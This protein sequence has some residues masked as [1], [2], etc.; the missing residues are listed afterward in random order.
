MLWAMIIGPE[1][2][3]RRIPVALDRKQAFFIEGI[4][5]SIEMIETAH[6]RLQGTLFEITKSFTGN[7]GMP[8]ELLA[9]AMLDAWCAVDC[10][11][12]LADLADHV[13]NV[14]RRRRIPAFRNLLA[15]NETVNDL[16]NTVQHLP[17]RIREMPVGPN[18]SVWGAL[19]W[20]VPQE[21]E[22]RLID[23]CTYVCGKLEHDGQRPLLNPT[24]K[25]IRLPVGLI[26][27]SQD[28][29]SVCVSDLLGLAERFVVEFEKMTAAAFKLNPLFAE[30]HPSD[31][32]IRLT[33]ASGGDENTS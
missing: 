23:S 5:V 26:T 7:R 33:M 8:Q 28:P 21:G 24:G 16:R 6:T 29:H 22:Q 25:M 27:L 19:S 18:W 31:I 11:H 30:T 17:A 12:G 14:I 10:F 32:L 3:L 2:C 20:C 1:S 13:P 9:A 4:R 15:A